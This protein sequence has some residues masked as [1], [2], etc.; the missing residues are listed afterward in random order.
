MLRTK[1]LSEKTWPLKSVQGLGFYAENE[2]FIP[3]DLAF[4]VQ[5][6]GFYAENEAFIREDLAFK[7]CSGFGVLLS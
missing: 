4:S 7:I 5:G 6:L 3:E 1:P 2:A